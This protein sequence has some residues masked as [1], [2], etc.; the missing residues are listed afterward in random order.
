MAP[1]ARW[2]AAPDHPAT[3]RSRRPFQPAHEVRARRRRL[4]G[5][6]LFGASA[7][8][9]VNALF[10]DN[11]FLATVQARRDY[12][13]VEA[14]LSRVRAENQH[15]RDQIHRVREDPTRLE[16][17]ARGRHGL[18]KPGETLVIVKPP[19]SPQHR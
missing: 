6:S 5:W 3:R 11:G 1:D 7:V 13:T 8:L 16:E 10:G 18:I 9:L 4:V 17:L 2:P 19:A 12:A 15:L 14:S